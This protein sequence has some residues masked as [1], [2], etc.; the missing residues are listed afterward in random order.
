MVVHAFHS[1]SREAEVNESLWVRGQPDLKSSRM[2]RTLQRNPDSWKRNNK[3]K[4]ETKPTLTKSTQ[5]RKGL[6]SLYTFRWQSITEKIEG[7]NRNLEEH[8]FPACSLSFCLNGGS[9]HSGL[10]PPTSIINEDM[11][12]LQAKLIKLAFNEVLTSGGPPGCQADNKNWHRHLHIFKTVYSCRELRIHAVTLEEGL[13]GRKEKGL[14]GLES[15]ESLKLW[16]IRCQVEPSLTLCY[17]KWQ[18]SENKSTGQ[19][20]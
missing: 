8:R 9:T 7:R 15:P 11:S 13:K 18:S 17:S 4:Q 5:R 3:T 20:R 2:A 19:M 1:S 12:C 16:L 14:S 10:G 6:I